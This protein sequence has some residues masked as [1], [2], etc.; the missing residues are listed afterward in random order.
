MILKNTV[1][2]FPHGLPVKDLGLLLQWLGVAAVAC[3][4]PLAQELPHAAGAAKKK[5]TIEF[6]NC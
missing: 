5:S 6:S 3:V 2:E 1:E 4:R